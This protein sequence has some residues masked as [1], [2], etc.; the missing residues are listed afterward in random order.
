MT[1]AGLRG[2]A[3]WAWAAMAVYAGWCG[4]AYWTLLSADAVY[5]WHL[6]L[7][8]IAA[9]LFAFPRLLR[10]RGAIQARRVH[11]VLVSVGWSAFVAMPLATLLRDA[12]P[13]GVFTISLLWFGGCTALAFL[14]SWLLSRHA[15]RALPLFMVL[16][17]IAL[18]EPG[19]VLVR[20]A[21]EHDW[22]AIGVLLPVLHATHALL[23]APVANAYRK[24][25]VGSRTPPP[26][27]GAYALALVASAATFLFASAL[28][29][30]VMRIVL[31]M[32]KS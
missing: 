21:R 3:P 27:A 29:F 7:F 16:G 9:V 8:G 17:C 22:E 18:A 12:G 6:V 31:S 26:D 19:L 4:Y 10:P 14:W 2:M 5:I 24:S 28:W 15:W 25:F 13:G 20:L 11:F 23:L 32:V 30:A 1:F